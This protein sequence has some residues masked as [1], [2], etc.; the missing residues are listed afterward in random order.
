MFIIGGAKV[1]TKIKL[2]ENVVKKSDMILVGGA[3][4]FTFLKSM[5]HEVGQ[6]LIEEDYLRTAEDIIMQA[7]DN[8]VNLIFPS[9]VVCVKDIDNPESI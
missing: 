3:M 9:D 1:S 8:N 7:S 2:I 5:G 4:A 6:S